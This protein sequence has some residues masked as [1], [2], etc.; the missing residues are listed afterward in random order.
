VKVF[1]TGK[2]EVVV[3]VARVADQ[4]EDEIVDADVVDAQTGGE[5]E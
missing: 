5:A 1:N 4:G 3:S 2:G